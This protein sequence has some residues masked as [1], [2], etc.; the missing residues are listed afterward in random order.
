MFDYDS[1]FD[2]SKVRA[3]LY[4]DV[5]NVSHCVYSNRAVGESNGPSKFQSCVLDQWTES[6]YTCGNELTLESFFAQ[7]KLS[8]SDTFEMHYYNP[9]LGRK[10]G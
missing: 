4:C 10:D 8:C 3:V 6:G 7:Q 1:T 2:A 5:C 9:L